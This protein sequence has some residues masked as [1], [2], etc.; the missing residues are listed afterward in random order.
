MKA[1]SQTVAA[2]H[3][4]LLSSRFGPKRRANQRGSSLILAMA[5]MVIGTLSV[6]AMM[7]YATVS[8]RSAEAY[9]RSTVG[10]Q[11]AS[12]VVD[13]AIAEIRG[14]RSLGSKGGT[15]TVTV[16]YESAQAVCTAEAGSGVANPVGGYADRT[17]RCTGSYSGNEL[18]WTRVQLLDNN[19]DEPG[20]V[21]QVLERRVGN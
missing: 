8:L 20:A 6:V 11:A 1:P 12:D 5:I 21:A 4:A 10:M 17:M 2:V 19:G 14:D 7:S 9:Q 18:L 15:E 16:D 3:V 13:L